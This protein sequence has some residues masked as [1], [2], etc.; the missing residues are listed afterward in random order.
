MANK[1]DMT[2]LPLFLD[3]DTRALAFEPPAVELHFK[4]STV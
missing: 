3:S 4:Q 1:Y 2:V